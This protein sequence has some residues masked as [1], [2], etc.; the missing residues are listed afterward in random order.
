MG[1]WHDY[2]RITVDPAASSFPQ[3][4]PPAVVAVDAD[5]RLVFANGRPASLAI[6]SRT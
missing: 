2:C 6:P 1:D 5:G 4:A 3:N